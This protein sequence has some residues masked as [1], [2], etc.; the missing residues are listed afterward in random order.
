MRGGSVP[1][2]RRAAS[3]AR[4]ATPAGVRPRRQA[5]IALQE[6]ELQLREQLQVTLPSGDMLIACVG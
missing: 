6:L 4:E 5:E 1:P 3:A 2:G